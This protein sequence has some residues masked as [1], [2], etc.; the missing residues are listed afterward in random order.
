MGCGPKKGTLNPQALKVKA[1]VGLL[2]CYLSRS[3]ERCRSWYLGFE[4][5][6]Q[7][8]KSVKV[9]SVIEVPSVLVVELF[10]AECL[11]FDCHWI[12]GH[13]GESVQYSFPDPR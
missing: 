1:S 8:S 10:V 7:V 6:Y 5:R 3:L 13:V 12:E 9:F 11:S 4:C 2:K